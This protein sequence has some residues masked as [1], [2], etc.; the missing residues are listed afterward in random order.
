MRQKG[1]FNKSKCKKCKYSS[2]IN[3]MN[4][5]SVCCN[6]LIINESSCLKNIDGKVV[7]IRGD[8]YNNCQLYEAGKRVRAKENWKL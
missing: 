4:V 1:K 8:D 7:D 2:K 5:T 6:Y 3:G